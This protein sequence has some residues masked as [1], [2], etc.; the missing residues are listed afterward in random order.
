MA[1]TIDPTGMSDPLHSIKGGQRSQGRVDATDFRQFAKL[2]AN[3]HT[4]DPAALRE[5]A[6]QFESVFTKMMLESMRAASFGD[7]LFGSD[8]GDM[9]QDM[10]DDQLAIEM[11]QGKGLGLADLLIRQLSHGA[12]PKAPGQIESTGGAG[13]T[14]KQK[15]LDMIGP[16]AEKAGRELGI[17]PRAIIAQAALETGWGRSTPGQES[18]D[19][20]SNNL[21]GIKAGASWKGAS[22][23][24]AT[25][26]YANGVARGETASFRAYEDAQAS[27]SDYV[28]L[29][30]DN[31]RYAAALNTGGDVR[32]FATALQ[33]G[34]YATDPDYANKLV[35]VARQV[36]EQLDHRQEVA[37]SLKAGHA[38]PINPLES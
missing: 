37:A 3:A 2:R 28:S 15:F 20:P 11:S 25:H 38:G 14:A 35:D 34:G 24:S 32:A 22:V 12:N 31:P 5:V 16:A 33:R 29:L 23:D 1:L 6:R 18:K 27:V 17:D 21:F 30:R 4:D 26:E 19:G 9:Y 36:A 7:P 10:M 8:Q 13:D